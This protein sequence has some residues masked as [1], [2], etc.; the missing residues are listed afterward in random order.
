M[1][2]PA[3]SGCLRLPGLPASMSESLRTFFAEEQAHTAMFRS[4]NARAA[5]QFY[6]P[7]RHY[8]FIRL[9]VPCRWLLRNIASRTYAL[10][11]LMLLA[12]LQEERSLHYSKHCLRYASPLERHFLG[13]HRTHLAD[14]TGHVGWDEQL[15]DWLWPRTSRAVRAATAKLLPAM[16]GEY[17]LLPKRSGRNVVRQLAREFPGLDRDALERAMSGLRHNPAFLRTLYSPQIVPRSLQRLAQLPEFTLLAR[18]LAGYVPFHPAT[19]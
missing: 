16:L 19:V 18:R 15:L 17:F 13:L 9:P 5:P 8:H 4:L 2:S 11:L 6:H 14:E 1:L 12:L 7:R 3:L 10:P